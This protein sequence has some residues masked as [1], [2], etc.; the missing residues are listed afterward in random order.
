MQCSNCGKVVSPSEAQFDSRSGP[1]RP[2]S[3]AFSRD[4]VIPIW[5]CSDCAQSRESVKRTFLWS[6]AAILIALIIL[7]TLGG[8]LSL[9]W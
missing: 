7:A 2:F 5:L 6:F 1:G 9:R 4:K 8:L 3:S